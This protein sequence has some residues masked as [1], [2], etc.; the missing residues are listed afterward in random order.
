MAVPTSVTETGGNR[1]LNAPS[2]L[3]LECGQTVEVYR[4][5]Q[6]RRSHL[7]RARRRPGGVRARHPL[8]GAVGPRIRA[9][10]PHG[11]GLCGEAVEENRGDGVSQLSGG[12]PGVV[13][14]AAS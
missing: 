14:L 12:V 8:H 13:V 6:R 1:A 5:G 3:S 9:V 2:G 4:L 11:R 7:Y 10:A